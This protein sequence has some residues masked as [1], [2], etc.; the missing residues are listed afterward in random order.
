MIVTRQTAIKIIKD[1]ALY[2]PE[3][4]AFVIELLAR[5]DEREKADGCVGCAF[6]DVNEWEMPCARCKRNSKDYWRPK[7]K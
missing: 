2:N 6:I 7:Q 1:D 3:V 5:D 4:A